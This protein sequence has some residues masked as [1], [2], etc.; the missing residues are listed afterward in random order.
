MFTNKRV[1]E[2]G[3]DSF[4]LAFKTLRGPD[5]KLTIHILHQGPPLP[6]PI[7]LVAFIACKLKGHEERLYNFRDIDIINNGIRKPDL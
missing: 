5:W 1:K 6:N 3:F 4:A 2:V 7:F